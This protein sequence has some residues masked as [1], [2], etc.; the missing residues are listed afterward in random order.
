[1]RG[2]HLIRD[3]KKIKAELFIGKLGCKDLIIQI[4][5]TPN[6]MKLGQFRGFQGERESGVSHNLD[7]WSG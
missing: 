3:G 2:T 5:F 6:A 1:M 7:W 4:H